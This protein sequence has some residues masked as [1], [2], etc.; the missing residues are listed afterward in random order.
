MNLDSIQTGIAELRAKI[1]RHF[2]VGPVPRQDDITDH[3]CEECWRARDDFALQR[4]PD[5]KRETIDNNFESLPLLT[6][7]AFHYNLP[8]YLVRTL[9][10]EGR[11]W[12]SVLDWVM[13]ALCLCSAESSATRFSLLLQDKL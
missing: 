9:D 13:N 8:A 1:V 7:S 3:E 4:W 5:V 10:C 12:S 11:S 2:P 6:P